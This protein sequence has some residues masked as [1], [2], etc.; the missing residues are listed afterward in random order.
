MFQGRRERGI[1]LHRIIEE[2][3][4]GEAAETMPTLAAPGR[5]C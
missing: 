5:I 4:S 3:L 2:V 1:V